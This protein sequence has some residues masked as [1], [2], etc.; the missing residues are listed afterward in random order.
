MILNK[1]DLKLIGFLVIVI[2]L[3]IIVINQKKDD[4]N[5]LAIVKHNNEIILS[6]D[7]SV[8]NTYTVKG[9]QGDVLIVVKDGKIKVEEENSPLHLCSKQGF[10]EQSYETIVCLPNRISIEIQNNDL[11]A[12]V[13]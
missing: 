2:I 5:K 9:D 1:S 6:I 3:S 7:L 13:R 8:D 12:V 11:D 10:I 4:G